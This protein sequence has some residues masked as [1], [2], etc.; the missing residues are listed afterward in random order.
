[1]FK[2][3]CKFFMNIFCMVT[4]CVV[5]A[6]ALFTTIINPTE[7]IPSVTLWQILAISALTSLLGTLSY[8]WDRTM[9][10]VEMAVRAG[11]H[12]VMCVMIVLCAGW[13]FD[14]YNMTVRNVVSMVACI[15][16]IF[17]AVSVISWTRSAR[18]AKQM[19][20]KLQEY[21]R[22]QECKFLKNPV[23]KR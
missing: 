17:A 23:D 6:V 10:R 3:K 2:R 21:Q 4:A 18:D 15:T 14:W 9:G 12:Y 22:R 16:V 1:M 11:I 13:L 19:N 7:T 8:P 20:E 5:P